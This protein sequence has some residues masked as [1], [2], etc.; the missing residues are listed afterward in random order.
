[1][2][3][4]KLHP[5]KAIQAH[6][7]TCTFKE[8]MQVCVGRALNRHVPCN[9]NSPPP[10]PIRTLDLCRSVLLPSIDKEVQLPLDFPA[11]GIC[12]FV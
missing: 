4:S 7:A 8:N 10:K 1:M 9:P 12:A 3:P 2:Y 6:P 11:G 5:G